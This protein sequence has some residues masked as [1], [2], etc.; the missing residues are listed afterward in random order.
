MNG[1][2]QF[3]GIVTDGSFK[4]LLPAITPGTR[5]TAIALQEA[6]PPEARELNLTEYEGQAIMV[7]GHDGGGWIY[8]AEVIDVAG[9]IL[10]AVVQQVFGETAKILET[11]AC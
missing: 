4:S 9:P 2:S 10:T 1:N 8:S 6:M 3:L 11:A 7:R 5:L